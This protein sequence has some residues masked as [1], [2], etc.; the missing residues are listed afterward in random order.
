VIRFAA[1]LLCS[2]AQAGDIRLPMRS[3]EVT[4]D[5]VSET[6]VEPVDTIRAD[7]WYVIESDGPLFVLTS[8]TGI[9]EVE[10]IAGP[11]TFR[12]RFAGGDKIETRTFSGP[13]L[14]LVTALKPGRAEV[15]VIPQGVTCAE[16]IIRQVLTVSGQGPKPP[17]DPEPEPDDPTPPGPVTSFRVIWILESGDT[18]N[19]AQTA[20]PDA[21]AVRDY[22]N[23]KTTRS[24]DGQPGWRTYDPQQITTNEPEVIQELWRQIKRKAWQTPCVAIEVNTHTIVLPFPANTA[25]ALA[26]LKRYGGE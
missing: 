4:P 23:A 8:P 26:L 7:E 5:P 10:S 24:P 11:M 14:H 13:H 9:L 16:D 15:I 12:G 19:A 2:V 21:K 18:L 17:P 22:V 6:R 20:I 3:V 1:I 25:D